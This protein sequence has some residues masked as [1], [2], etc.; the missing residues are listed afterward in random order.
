MKTIDRYPFCVMLMPNFK[1]CESGVIKYYMD[2]A[3][4]VLGKDS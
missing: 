3:N 1:C 4:G 2:P